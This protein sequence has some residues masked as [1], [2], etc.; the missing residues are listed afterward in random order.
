MWANSLFASTLVLRQ[1][2][3]SEAKRKILQTPHKEIENSFKINQKSLVKLV[4]RKRE[5]DKLRNLTSGVT[6]RCLKHR[7]VKNIKG[8]LKFYLLFPIKKEKQP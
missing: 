5:S 8:V 1:F 3:R 2:S 7:L 4:K 6:R